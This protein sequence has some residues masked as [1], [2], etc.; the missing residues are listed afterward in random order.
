MNFKIETKCSQK[1]CPESA[2]Q[3]SPLCMKHFQEHSQRPGLN[4]AKYT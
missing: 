4:N 1:N 3:S 2:L